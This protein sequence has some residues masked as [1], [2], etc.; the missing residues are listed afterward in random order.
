M[1]RVYC[2]DREFGIDYE[3]LADARTARHA[4]QTH[5]PRLRYYIR[6]VA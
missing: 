1:Y 6:K 4:F 2:E 3:N 5:W